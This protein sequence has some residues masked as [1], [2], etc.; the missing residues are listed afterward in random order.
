MELESLYHH[1]MEEHGRHA[2]RQAEWHL[3]ALHSLDH[4][5][6]ELGLLHLGHEHH[7]HHHDNHYAA[8]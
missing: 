1:M 5:E 2:S 3:A 8:R 7:H 6:Q 4:A